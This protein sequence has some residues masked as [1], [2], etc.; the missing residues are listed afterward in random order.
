MDYKFGTNNRN[1]FQD[2]LRQIS[3]DTEYKL[4]EGS[5]GQLSS[6]TIKN[7]PYSEFNKTSSYIKYADKPKLEIEGT[8]EDFDEVEDQDEEEDIE[9]TRDEVIKTIHGKDFD[10]IKKYQKYE[11]N[12]EYYD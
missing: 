1:R 3:E 12:F 5:I 10:Y 6:M 11:N 4:Y 7:H 9:R 2:V 8:I